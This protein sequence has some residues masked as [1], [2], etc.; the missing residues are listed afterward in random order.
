MGK[1]NAFGPVFTIESLT[2]TRRWQLYASRAIFVAVMLAGLEV[3]WWAETT[4]RSS[5]SILVL[6]EVG[7]R[8]FQAF[9]AMQLML[10]LLAAPAATAGAF[11]LDRSR[12]NLTQVLTTDL[13]AAEIVLGTLAAR[14]MPV[15]GMVI[16][17]APFLSLGMLLGGIDPNSLV[18]LLLVTVGSAVLGTTLALTLSI[19]GTRLSEVMSAT[20]AIWL[21]AVLLPPC[22][23]VLR[24]VGAVTWPMPKWVEAT[25]PVLLVVLPTLLPGAAGLAAPS[26]FLAISLILSVGLATLAAMRLRTA[27]SREPVRAKPRNYLRLPGPKLDL[28]PILW[29]E[30]YAR[31]PSRWGLILCVLYATAAVACT[32]TVAWATGQG[33]GRLKIGAAFLNALQVA[34]G[35]L[36]LSISA[37]SALGEERA[38]G[39][40]DVLL[41]TPLS[42]RSVVWGKWWGTFRLVST[43]R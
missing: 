6:S 32:A 40:L 22:W 42:T 41:A 7:H 35:M 24:A 31:R 3:V 9:A 18:C 16:S 20:Y 43:L 23:W 26:R 12:G 14:I 8:T 2:T 17:A 25:N 34:A 30:W 37:A 15:M 1:F 19:W 38:C 11:C 28:N 10:V 27:V 5:L 33:P 29:R 13:T 39:S 4:R 21:F 36:L